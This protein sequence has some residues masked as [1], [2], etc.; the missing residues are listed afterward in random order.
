MAQALNWH[1]VCLTL[2]ALAPA[3][4]VNAPKLHIPCSSS[5]DQRSAASTV[6]SAVCSAQWNGG[7]RDKTLPVPVTTS[8]EVYITGLNQIFDVAWT[9]LDLVSQKSVPRYLA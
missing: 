3:M 4:L 6:C 9:C 7:L 2:Q 1:F 5:C 8:S